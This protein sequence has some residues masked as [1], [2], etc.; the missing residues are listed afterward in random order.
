VTP[1]RGPRENRETHARPHP[2][3]KNDGVEI[4]LFS[5]NAPPASSFSPTNCPFNQGLLP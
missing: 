4:V 5:G 2:G 1:L 3:P